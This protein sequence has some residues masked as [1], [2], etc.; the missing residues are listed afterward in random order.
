[1]FTVKILKDGE[2]VDSSRHS[3]EEDAEAQKQRFISEGYVD[4]D[5]L[6]VEE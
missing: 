1:M 4:S 6:I 3:K 5:I 2:W